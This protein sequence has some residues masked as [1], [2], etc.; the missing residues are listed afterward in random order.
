[1]HG[2]I[3]C[4]ILNTGCIILKTNVNNNAVIILNKNTTKKMNFSYIFYIQHY[5]V[6]TLFNNRTDIICTIQ[7]IH[8]VWHLIKCMNVVLV[9]ECC[10]FQ[11]HTT[12]IISEFAFV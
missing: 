12:E 7:S 3:I 9:H 5:D 8:I 1:M 10:S 6:P 11:I 4:S 2:H